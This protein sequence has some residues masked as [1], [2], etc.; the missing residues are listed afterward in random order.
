MVLKTSSRKVKRKKHVPDSKLLKAIIKNGGNLTHAAHDLGIK[1]PS[2]SKRLIEHPELKITIQ[3]KINQ[4]LEEAGITTKRVYGQLSDQ[5]SA[6][7][8]DKTPDWLAQDKARKDALRLMGHLNDIP[9]GQLS[10]GT[11]VVMPVIKIDGNPLDFKI[12]KYAND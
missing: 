7:S 5:L 12:G 10:S 3:E 1:Q 9:D 8:I 11:V 2:V 6:K 4:C